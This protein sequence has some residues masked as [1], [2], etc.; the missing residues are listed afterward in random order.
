MK[1]DLYNLKVILVNRYK[2]PP[3]K[4][5]GQKASKRDS[6][7]SRKNSKFIS[8]FMEVGDTNAFVGRV[9]GK[10][11][12]GRM[13]VFYLDGK[14]PKTVQAVIRGTFRGKGKR[15]VWI[16]VGSIVLLTDSG[17]DGARQ[18]EIMAILSP[19]DIQELKKSTEL[20]HRILAVDN[21]DKA[22]LL[23]E[24]QP[25]PSGG[26]DFIAEEEEVELDEL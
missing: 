2:M 21:V 24:K 8:S 5:S 19:N 17:L 20:D 12:S 26:F 13:D 6:G 9:I 15:S 3:Q 18:F 22:A 11:G 16:D 1:T 4:N 25:D 14:Y 7:V 10:C 23:A